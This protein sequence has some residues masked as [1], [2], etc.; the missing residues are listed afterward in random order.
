MA[1]LH[2]F[3]CQIHGRFE[4]RVKAGTVPRCPSGCSKSFVSLIFTKP[5]GHVSARTRTGDRLVREMAD[6]QGL[7][8]ISTSPSRPGG[9]VAERNRM[10]GPRGR[11][12]LAYPEVAAAQNVPL[13]VSKAIPA[14]TNKND[15][16]NAL[17]S[18]GFGNKYDASQWKK[19]E[20]TGVVKH[21]D[22][23]APHVTVPLGSTGVSIDRVKGEPE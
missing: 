22:I 2:D 21:V 14:L 1:V 3:E 6:M 7:S 11:P 17:T 16:A 8:D 5:P 12:D 20:K 15:M 23:P 9:S 10:R 19:D 13:N 18:I 4:K